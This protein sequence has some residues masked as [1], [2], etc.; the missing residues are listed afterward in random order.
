MTIETSQSTLHRLFDAQPEEQFWYGFAYGL[1]LGQYFLTLS[2]RETDPDG[3]KVI[4][5]LKRLYA[6]DEDPTTVVS[7]VLQ[8][9]PTGVFVFNGQNA[10]FRFLT[11][12][13]QW[14]EWNQH[15]QPQLR[16]LIGTR[17]IQLTSQGTV[18]NTFQNDQMW[19]T[20][21][22]EGVPLLVETQLNMAASVLRR[23]NPGDRIL[24][25]LAP[26]R[27]NKHSLLVLRE[28]HHEE[29]TTRFQNAILRIQGEI[30]LTPKAANGYLQVDDKGHFHLY[31]FSPRNMLKKIAE[32]VHGHL[33]THPALGRLVGLRQSQLSESG[34][35][36]STFDNPEL[37]EGMERPELKA[38]GETLDALRRSLKAHA[39]G[40]K[41]HFDF[42]AEGPSGQPLLILTPEGEDS[43]TTHAQSRKTLTAGV[44]PLARPLGGF[45]T[46]RKDGKPGL[47]F[48]SKNADPNFLSALARFVHNNVQ[49]EPALRVLSNSI[50]A[51]IDD[52]GKPVDKFRDD[53]LWN[54]L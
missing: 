23:A 51:V 4:R 45:A 11:Q 3:A 21:L 24:F 32:L 38:S 36:V 17:Y 22:P 14:V 40:R 50:Y 41:F 29:S 9:D 27:L 30:G 54:N 19:E 47:S 31:S 39:P 20:L 13:K 52:A 33:D 37:W 5:T 18:V 6:S 28:T 25:W 42:T 26:N 35:V 49:R 12:L 2:S 15:R 53:S 1:S 44:R 16:R 10:D 7:G 48:R 43:K 8:V 34:D 46:A